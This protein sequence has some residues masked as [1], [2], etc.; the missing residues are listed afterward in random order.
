VG[1]VGSG[2]WVERIL[3][4]KGGIGVGSSSWQPSGWGWRRSMAPKSGGYRGI[5]IIQKAG[6]RS[7]AELYEFETFCRREQ[8]T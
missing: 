1:L 6:C 8:G 5:M 7:F 3:A 4:R 2:W